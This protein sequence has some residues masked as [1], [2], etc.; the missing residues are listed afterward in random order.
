M[1]IHKR[2]ASPHNREKDAGQVIY[3]GG[4]YFYATHEEVAQEVEARGYQ[5]CVF[6]W[7]DVAIYSS[8]QNA[9]WCHVQFPD[10]S[11]ADRAK[12]SL[13]GISFKGLTWKT[14]ALSASKRT[15]NP[16]VRIKSSRNSEYY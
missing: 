12:G 9:G 2:I 14:G 8:Q 11:T 1:F 6:Y 5:D 3:L 7:P 16:I 15:N 10:S 4:I 13:N